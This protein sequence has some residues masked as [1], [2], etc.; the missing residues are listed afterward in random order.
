MKRCTAKTN[1]TFR[2]SH[3]EYITRNPVASMT[4][5]EFSRYV[6]RIKTEE[7]NLSR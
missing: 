3:V 6:E 1:I 5:E 7:K 4:T 2:L